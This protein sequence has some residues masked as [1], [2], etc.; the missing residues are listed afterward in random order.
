MFR[1]VG[2]GLARGFEAEA[3]RSGLIVGVEEGV[4]VVV[5]DE[6]VFAAVGSGRGCGAQ[7]LGEA[8]VEAFDHAVGLRAE[9]SREQVADAGGGAAVAAL[10]CNLMSIRASSETQAPAQHPYH[11]TNSPA[12]NTLVGGQTADAAPDALAPALRREEAA[13]TWPI[14]TR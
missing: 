6:A 7:R 4:S 13:P 12:P 14:F 2:E 10:A 1:E 3:L 11:Q 5:I 8:P 9:G